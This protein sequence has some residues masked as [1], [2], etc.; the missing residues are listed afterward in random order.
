MF[1]RISIP[2][3]FSPDQAGDRLRE[4]VRPEGFLGSLAHNVGDRRP[5][6]G[7]SKGADFRFYRRRPWHN[8][9][10]PIISG[11]V[12]PD[13]GGA[14]FDASFRLALPVLVI[15][16]V[17]LLF[18]AIEGA[19]DVHRYIV[20][21]GADGSIGLPL[22]VSLFAAAGVVSYRLEKRSAERILREALAP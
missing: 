1:S 8:S 6:I 2:T 9:F 3:R 17:L 15:V 14:V 10:T 22:F 11:T 12:K 18:I 21:S 4:L 16:P 20:T 5:F 19:G 13:A 7:R